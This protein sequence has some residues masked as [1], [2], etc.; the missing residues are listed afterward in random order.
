VA[1]NVF[2]YQHAPAKVPMRPDGVPDVVRIA[3]EFQ[4]QLV[5]SKTPIPLA[6]TR[7]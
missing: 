7:C 6:G 4:G 3:E 5:A 1:I 2:V